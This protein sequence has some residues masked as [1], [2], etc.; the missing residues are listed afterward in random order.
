MSNE[1]WKPIKG[2]ECLYEVSTMGRVRRLRKTPNGDIG[3]LLKPAI[4]RA[5][6][7]RVRLCKEG[8]VFAVYVHRLV[9]STFLGERSGEVNHINGDKQ[10]NRLDN[11]EWCTHQENMQK[12]ADTGL[13]NCTAVAQSSDGVTVAV[14]PSITDASKKIGGSKSNIAKCCNG[15]RKTAY[16]Y[17]WR[18]C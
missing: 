14:Y 18:G 15:Q 3:S 5:G 10:D 13:I 6:Y 2:Y 4:D 17:E 12:A 16:G 1:S 8:T 11:L 9:A 7:K